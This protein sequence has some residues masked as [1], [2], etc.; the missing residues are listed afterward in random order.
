M[1]SADNEAVELPGSGFLALLRD[2]EQ[3][4]QLN[5]PGL[6]QT[7]EAPKVWKGV[8]FRVAGRLTLAPLDQVREVLNRP[9]NVTAIPGTKPWVIGVA[10]NR[11]TLLPIYDLQGFLTGSPSLSHAQNRV[12][13][14][15]QEE[16]PFGLLVGNVIGIRNLEASARVEE[17]PM[18]NDALGPFVVAGFELE[19]NLHP[20]FSLERLARDQRFNQ[21]PA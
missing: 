11:G 6:P 20:V 9:A 4:C 19:G 21:A 8:L 12:L 18:L 15:R 14:V 5:A 2:I 17:T 7:E 16:L 3:R 1:A 10:N 13:V